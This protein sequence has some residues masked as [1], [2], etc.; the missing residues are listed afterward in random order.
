MRSPTEIPFP[1]HQ[2]A[3]DPAASES[4]SDRDR[5]RDHDRDRD[6]RAWVIPTVTTVLLVLLVPFAMVCAFGAAMSTDSCGSDECQALDKWVSVIGAT[7]LVGLFVTPGACLASWLVPWKQRWAATRLCL[8]LLALAP[9]SIVVC[10]T[11]TLP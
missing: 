11:L 5:D 4:D 7:L 1:T 10:L 9:P 2:L 8:A 3:T 6:D